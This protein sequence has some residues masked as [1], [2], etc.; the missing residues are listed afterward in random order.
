MTSL[1]AATLKRWQGGAF[2]LLGVCATR[3]ML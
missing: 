1:K 3:E 2:G